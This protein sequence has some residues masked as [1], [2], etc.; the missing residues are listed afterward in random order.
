MEGSLREGAIA[1]NELPPQD[2]SKALAVK[3]PTALG[4]SNPGLSNAAET[5][6]S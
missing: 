5:N 4:E 6:S 3:S 1:V 2:T